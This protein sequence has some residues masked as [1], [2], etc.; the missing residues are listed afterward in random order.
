MAARIMQLV[1]SAG[2][3]RARMV[4]ACEAYRRA[5]KNPFTFVLL[6]MRQREYL[7][8]DLNIKELLEMEQLLS[9]ATDLYEAYGDQERVK[10]I[11][12]IARDSILTATNVYN[13]AVREGLLSAQEQD[14][15]AQMGTSL[16]GTLRW[17]SDRMGGAP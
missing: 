12:V 6:K 5:R 11:L 8:R 16:R 10:K 14:V 7:V 9:I 4:D 15:L 17:F 3:F 13:D 1:L 2:T